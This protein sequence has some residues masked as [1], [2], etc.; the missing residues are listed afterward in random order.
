MYFLV[1]IGHRKWFARDHCMTILKSA[2]PLLLKDSTFTN[3]LE[4]VGDDE[5]FYSS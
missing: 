3:D 4:R 5:P 1:I 2:E